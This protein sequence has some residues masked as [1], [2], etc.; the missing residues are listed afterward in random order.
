MYLLR[1]NGL[2]PSSPGAPAAGL[3]WRNGRAAL[4]AAGSVSG[5]PN[6]ISKIL[7]GQLW[8][9]RSFW[10]A[11]APL[12]EVLRLLI[13][14]GVRRYDTIRHKVRGMIYQAGGSAAY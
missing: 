7:P 11:G 13:A 1:W 8:R 10:S 2:T 5:R 14:T 6:K 9:M 12:Q 3:P 4:N